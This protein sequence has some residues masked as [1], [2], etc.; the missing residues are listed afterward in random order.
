[1]AHEHDH[2]HGA[3]HDAPIAC[4]LGVFTPEQKR[5]HQALAKKLAGAIL[6]RRE[7]DRG[8]ALKVASAKIGIAEAGEWML[9]EGKCCSFLELTLDPEGLDFW[10]NLT[11]R[12]GVKEFLKQQLKF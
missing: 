7:L 11:G 6:E 2:H 5:R 1:M 3:D 9:L 4:N 8:Y 10:I 12:E